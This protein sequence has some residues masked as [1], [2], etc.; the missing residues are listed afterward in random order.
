[1]KRVTF[2]II[3]VRLFVNRNLSDERL[4]R[5]KLRKCTNGYPLDYRNIAS[6]SYFCWDFLVNIFFLTTI[7]LNSVPKLHSTALQV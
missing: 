7:V 4:R 2:V 5:Q 1:M 6:L 3:V